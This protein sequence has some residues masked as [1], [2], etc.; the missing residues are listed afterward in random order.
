MKLLLDIG[1]SRLKWACDDGVELTHYGTLVR[2]EQLFLLLPTRWQDLPRP[3]RIVASN[4]AG[5]AFA[6]ELD[7]FVATFWSLKVEYAVVEQEWA[8]LTIAYPQPELFGVDRWLAL[9]AARHLYS[10]AVSVVDCGT[11]VTIDVVDQNGQHLGGVI[12]PG[13]DLMQR[14]LISCSDGVSRGVANKSVANGWVLGRDTQSGVERGALYAVA[15]VITHT[16]AKVKIEVDGPLTSI[17]TGGDAIR[18]QSE[19]GREYHYSPSLVL[20]GLQLLF[21]R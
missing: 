17:I 16:L 14:T 12:V 3:Q 9:I 10:G 19:I 13:I 21:G 8:G 15:G 11:A 20:H 6:Q 2:D 1:N 7:A 5:I 4:V 18:V